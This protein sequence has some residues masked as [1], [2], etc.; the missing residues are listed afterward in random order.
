[1]KS[2]DTKAD[3]PF[4]VCRVASRPS[5]AH[6]SLLSHLILIHLRMIIF[7][8]SN[9]GSYRVAANPLHLLF[10]VGAYLGLLKDY[11]SSLLS[12]LGYGF[13]SKCYP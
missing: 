4:V 6:F 11:T 1:M 9:K 2:F 12:Y 5:H 13:M 10:D 7:I 3:N 8:E